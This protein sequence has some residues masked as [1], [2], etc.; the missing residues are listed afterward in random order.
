[1]RRG[2]LV[3]LFSVVAG[4]AL[5]VACASEKAGALEKFGSECDRASECAP[6]LVC[7]QRVCTDDLSRL[8][9]GGIPMF[10]SGSEA[11]VMDGDEAGEVDPDAPPPPDTGT[12]D[13]GL[14][15][16]RPPPDTA[17]VDTKPPPDTAP[18]PDTEPPPD[19]AIED[20]ASD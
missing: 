10:D 19:T 17:M 7:V 16:T 13:T 14:P 11:V 20:T 8:D 3:V 6:G 2:A 9:G 4:V 18:P 5:A 12:P 15:D 1:V